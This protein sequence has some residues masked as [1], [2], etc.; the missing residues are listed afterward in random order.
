VSTSRGLTPTS[1]RV[2]GLGD[3]LRYGGADVGARARFARANAAG[4]VNG[5]TIDYQGML[6][7]GGDQANDAK[8]ADQ[9]VAQ[10][11]VFA[12]VPVVT[13]ALA[14]T[15]FTSAKVPFFGWALSTAFCDN[16]LGY[17]FDGCL[18]PPGGTVTSGAW[19]QLAAAA[20][21]PGPQR[22]AA[23]LAESTP[24]GVYALRS[25][26]AS[27]QAAGLR[28]AMGESKLPVPAV[29]D[30][31]ATARA[32]MAS[33][34]GHAP[35]IVF[36]IGSYSNVLLV[37]RALADAGYH[38]AFTDAIEYAPQLVPGAQGTLVF[39]QTAPVESAGTTPAMQQLVDDVREVAPGQAIDQSV[40]AG[41][42]SADLFLQVLDQRPTR[43]TASRFA[44]A[45]ERFSFSVP[46][47]VGPTRFPSAHREPTPCGSLV[48]STGLAFSVAVP[49]TCGTVVPVS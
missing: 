45:A 44:Q 18:T 28:V 17:G 5:R 34:A 30:Y 1:V 19:G 49:Y 3:S 4:G 9:L 26:T 6:D 7:D 40:I 15:A 35:D 14:P 27:V 32:V 12:A 24:S 16:R 13:D 31:G 11:Q 38:G 22:S 25:L 48:R 2:A 8:L 37:R 46:G 10:N 39:V 20:L 23:L 43:L 33:D 29:G 41:Y 42:L 21:G 36:V 47:V